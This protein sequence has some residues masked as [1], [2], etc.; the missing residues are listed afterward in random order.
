MENIRK[1]WRVTA[2][3]RLLALLAALKLLRWKV[4]AEVRQ[5][6]ELNSAEERAMIGLLI[7][8]GNADAVGRSL[9]AMLAVDIRPGHVSSIGSANGLRRVLGVNV[10]PNEI[11]V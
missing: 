7:R 5:C 6:S 11:T 10:H 3:G 1:I 9:D 2:T 4:D 8:H